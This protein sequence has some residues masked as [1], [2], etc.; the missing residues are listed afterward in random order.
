MTGMPFELAAA[1]PS[2]S[3]VSW[4]LGTSRDAQ[5]AMVRQSAREHHARGTGQGVTWST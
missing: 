5:G 3:P 1:P 2:C 4:V